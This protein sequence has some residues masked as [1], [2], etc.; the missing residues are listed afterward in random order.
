MTLKGLKGHDHF[1]I[2]VFIRTSHI[3]IKFRYGLILINLAHFCNLYVSIY[4]L[5][6]SK[7]IVK[8]WNIASF[9]CPAPACCAAP[10]PK[11]FVK[12]GFILDIHNSN[13]VNPSRIHYYFWSNRSSQKQT[14][15]VKSI[16][17]TV[18]G[19]FIRGCYMYYDKV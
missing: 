15:N 18:I 19:R 13:S 5:S 17:R 4:I 1:L 12:S 9:S 2:C 11:K 16:G 3:H 7:G 10:S 8:M 14:N 6:V